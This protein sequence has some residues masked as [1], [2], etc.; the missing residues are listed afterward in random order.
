[1][2]GFCIGDSGDPLFDGEWGESRLNC[3]LK[4]TVMT[5][6]ARCPVLLYVAILANNSRF[7]LS[8]VV[9]TPVTMRDQPTISESVRMIGAFN[10]RVVLR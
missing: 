9:Q 7:V 4:L 1:M 8:L 10:A 5:P 6:I 2:Q 3:A